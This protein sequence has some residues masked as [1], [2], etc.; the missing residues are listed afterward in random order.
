MEELHVVKFVTV[1]GDKAFWLPF[2]LQCQ[3]IFITRLPLHVRVVEPA[4]FA[5]IISGGPEL[6]S[7]LR[8]DASRVSSI[9]YLAC[10]DVVKA[11]F[12]CVQLVSIQTL[13]DHGTFVLD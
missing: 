13:F 7:I 2:L 11:V 1:N 9:G 3:T 6:T 4:H 12:T 8:C 10:S 5:Q